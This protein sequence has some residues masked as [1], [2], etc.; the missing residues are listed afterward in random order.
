MTIP[1][2]LDLGEGLKY[3]YFKHRR[4]ITKLHKVRDSDGSL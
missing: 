3:Y 4:D 2:Y 1:P